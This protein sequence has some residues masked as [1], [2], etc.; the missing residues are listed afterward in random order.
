MLVCLSIEENDT[1]EKSSNFDIRLYYFRSPPPNKVITGK[2]E[3]KEARS[4]ENKNPSLSTVVKL[5]LRCF[6]TCESVPSKQKKQ[7]NKKKHVKYRLWGYCNKHVV[8][9]NGYVAS[10][11]K[12][13]LDEAGMSSPWRRPVQDDVKDQLFPKPP[14]STSAI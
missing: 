9:L 2:K 3:E 4:I 8:S 1:V 11:V 13:L 6:I 10:Y 12:T 5:S 7:K 14:F